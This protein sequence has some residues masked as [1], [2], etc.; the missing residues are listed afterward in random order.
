M[1]YFDESTPL[2]IFVLSPT[3]TTVMVIRLILCSYLI[4]NFSL[5][6]QSQ[7]SDLS[8]SLAN[9]YTYFVNYEAN[10]GNWINYYQISYA[11][12]LNKAFS[13]TAHLSFA[14]AAA[15][16]LY[17]GI[18]PFNGPIYETSGISSTTTFDLAM[19]WNVLNLRRHQ[20]GLYAG[21]SVKRQAIMDSQFRYQG[22]Q[23]SDLPS[24]YEP[25][26]MH[27]LQFREDQSSYESGTESRW[28]GGL[29]LAAEY[30]FY[31][32][33]RLGIGYT[34]RVRS[35]P[36]FFLED[37]SIGPVLR[38]RWADTPSE[39]SEAT[40]GTFQLQ[41]LPTSVR[42]TG[43]VA[44]QLRTQ[45]LHTLT[46]RLSAG[47]SVAYVQGSDFPEDYVAL[48]QDYYQ[49]QG[50]ALSLLAGYQLYQAGAHQL[51]LRAGPAFRWGARAWSEGYFNSTDEET[52]AFIYDPTVKRGDRRFFDDLVQVEVVR[53][54]GWG[55]NAQLAYSYQ[56]T[57]QLAVGGVVD[58]QRYSDGEALA[59]A[60]VSVEVYF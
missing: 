34:F 5:I 30:I 13:L 52:E 42:S 18:G 20:L 60:G 35:Q 17:A 58:Y 28:I 16:E 56:F 48:G 6:S 50:T 54:Q 31:P 44:T 40:G 32:I 8:V 22:V 24:G 49:Y 26:T 2:L 53:S 33:E 43:K 55:G 3:Y 1:D 4:L 11:H 14:Q 46:D 38:Y 29:Y 12:S 9:K 47:G 15:E 45:Y 36:Q 19:R 7:V 10:D 41:L 23:T 51:A 21:P 25:Y 59:G 57:P 39:E 27:R 37:A